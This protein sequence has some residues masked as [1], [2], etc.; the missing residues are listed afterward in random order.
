MLKITCYKCHWSWSL[1]REAVQA[2]LDS[3]EP[4]AKYYAVECPHCR[5]TNKV[6]I[7]QLKRALPRPPR[8]AEA[9]AK[10]ET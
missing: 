4:E 9:P 6:T 5:R 10:K 8:A 2:A 7:K 1:N 3:L